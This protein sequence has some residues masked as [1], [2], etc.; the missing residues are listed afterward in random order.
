M[1]ASSVLWPNSQ[2]TSF[3]PKGSNLSP[4]KGHRVQE[5]AGQTM[6]L[7]EEPSHFKSQSLYIHHG[8]Q[9]QHRDGSPDEEK[10]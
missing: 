3:H 10:V 5:E 9:S 8:G 1:S 2:D 4:R 7:S 6:G